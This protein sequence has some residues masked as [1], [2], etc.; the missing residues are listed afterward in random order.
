MTHAFSSYPKFNVREPRGTSLRGIRLL[1]HRSVLC[2]IAVRREA[3]HAL[4]F[5]LSS[6]VLQ[7]RYPCRRRVGTKAPGRLWGK[8]ELAFRC[9]MKS[10][11]EGTKYECEEGVVQ[12]EYVGKPEGMDHIV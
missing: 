5:E 7:L 6:T 1:F 10:A 3:A 9:A 2:V 12:E 8:R 11:D 4:L